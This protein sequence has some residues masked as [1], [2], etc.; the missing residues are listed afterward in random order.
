MNEWDRETTRKRHI[1]GGLVKAV[2][3]VLW[4]KASAPPKNAISQSKNCPGATKRHQSLPAG[5]TPG[6]STSTSSS[7]K[8]TCPNLRHR[9]FTQ[10][11]ND[12]GGFS[13]PEGP[14]SLL[15]DLKPIRKKNENKKKKKKKKEK[16]KKKK[17]KKERSV[18]Q[19]RGGKQI[20]KGGRG[21]E[22][23]KQKD[24]VGRGDQ[25]DRKDK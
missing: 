5:H 6:R 19:K 1:I 25:E 14:E 13:R 18:G 22:E 4:L 10:P 16:K 23:R 17:K 8:I 11:N 2:I 20:T 7:G 12:S 15:G 21:A 3:R 9:G 24:G